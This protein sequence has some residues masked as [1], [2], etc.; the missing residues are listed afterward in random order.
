MLAIVIPMNLLRLPSRRRS[1]LST[2]I[3]PSSNT[4]DNASFVKSLQVRR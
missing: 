3:F 4:V 2:R 1:G